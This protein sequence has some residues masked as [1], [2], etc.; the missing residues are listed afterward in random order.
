MALAIRED[1]IQVELDYGE[2][3]SEDILQRRKLRMERLHPVIGH[4]SGKPLDRS[5][6]SWE[7]FLRR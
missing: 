6:L 4:L 2:L 5:R 7:R 3:S 1:I